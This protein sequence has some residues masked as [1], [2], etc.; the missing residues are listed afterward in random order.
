VGRGSNIGSLFLPSKNELIAHKFVKE[1][2]LPVA[3]RVL[4][5]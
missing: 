2:I 4:K 3:D 5:K 1:K